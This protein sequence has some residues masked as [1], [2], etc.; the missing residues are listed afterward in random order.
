MST[1]MNNN[2]ETK[3]HQP[4]KNDMIGFIIRLH[5]A[6]KV[7]RQCHCDFN[8]PIRDR[9]IVLKDFAIFCERNYVDDEKYINMMDRIAHNHVYS[10]N[11]DIHLVLKEMMMYRLF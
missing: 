6:E 5:N 4:D 11:G 10:C 7:E 3:A 9:Y 8:C 2:E 1:A